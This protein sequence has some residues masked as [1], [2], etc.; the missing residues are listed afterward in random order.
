[1]KPK[2]LIVTNER[3]IHLRPAGRIIELLDNYK[4]EVFFLTAG[5]RVNARSMV[6]LLSLAAPYGTVLDVEVSGDDG[7]G[8][9]TA[10]HQLFTDNF[11][12]EE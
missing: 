12:E 9:L 6:D 4:A 10:L 5:Q 11:G 8:A 2:Q 1:M 7:D 3:G